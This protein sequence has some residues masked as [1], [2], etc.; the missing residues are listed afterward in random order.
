MF[1]FSVSCIFSLFLW[2]CL[3][4]FEFIEF[5]FNSLS[6]FIDFV[7]AFTLLLNLDCFLDFFIYFK[8]FSGLF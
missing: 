6:F 7:S 2:L 8:F 3:V 5:I 1:F 4:L